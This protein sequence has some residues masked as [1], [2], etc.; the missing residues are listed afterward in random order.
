MYTLPYWYVQ[1]YPSSKWALIFGLR[2]K[3][4]V[5]MFDRWDLTFGPTLTARARYVTSTSLCSTRPPPTPPAT[6][7]GLTSTVT[8]TW[9]PG[10]SPTSR[11]SSAWIR[12][13]GN[14]SLSESGVSGVVVGVGVR[15][16]LLTLSWRS[17]FSWVTFLVSSSLV[18]QF[19]LVVQ[20]TQTTTESVSLWC[21]SQRHVHLCCRFNMTFIWTENVEQTSYHDRE[22][23]GY[24]QRWVNVS[25]C[26]CIC[27][28]TCMYVY[29]YPCV[30]IWLFIYVCIFACNA[31]VYSIGL[32]TALWE[33]RWC[34]M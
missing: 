20:F 30:W 1:A 10:S 13:G 33:Y 15:V 6:G 7:H 27:V 34:R 14:W 28:V 29:I 2:M 4:P 22:F 18:Y 16:C 25:I 21:R 5:S 3:V 26:M 23:S 11:P 17:Q 9:T 32:S 12:S 24:C 19:M 8:A 31:F